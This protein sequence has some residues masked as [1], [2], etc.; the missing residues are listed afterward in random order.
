MRDSTI[1][2]EDGFLG[3]HSPLLFVGD[4]QSLEFE[5]E[6][7]GPFYLSP[8]QRALQRNDKPTGKHKF[9]ER[10]KKLLIDSLIDAGV[11]LQQQQS[12]TK[13][14]FKSAQGPTTLT[15]LSNERRFLPTGRANQK[16]S[17]KFCG[18]EV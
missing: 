15:Y 9:V 10:S 6:N 7:S 1:L 8:E 14:S 18:R 4:T 17:C 16:V 13:K 11:L 5:N 12:F 2:K 3:P